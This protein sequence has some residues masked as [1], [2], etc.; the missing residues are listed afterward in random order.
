MQKQQLTSNDL[1]AALDD[2]AERFSTLPIDDL[3]VLWFLRAYITESE[4]KAAEAVSGGA[5]DKGIDA[6]FID[7]AARSVFVVQGKY[8]KILGK[9]T[10]KRTD[11]VSLAEIARRLSDQDA[12]QFSTFLAKTE[13]YVAEQ[14]RL[15]R[16]RVLN[17][18]YRIWLY[19]VTLGKVS[20]STRKD[21]ASLVKAV[22][23]DASLEVIDGKRA[24]LLFQD[25]LDGVAPPIPTLDLEMEQGPHV[26]VNAISQR[27]DDQNNI[28]SW[29]FSMQGDAVARLY[30]YGGIRLFARNIRGFLGGSTAVNQGMVATLRKEPERFIYYNNGITILCDE[31]FKKSHK[32]RDILQ[33]SNPQVINGQQTT[34]TLAQHPEQ[35]RRASVLVKVIQVSREEDNTANGFEA[36][37]SRIVAGTNWQNAIRASDLMSNDRIQIDLE[38][39]L[40]KLGYAY[41]RKRQ[42]KGEAKRAAGGKH[43]RFLK[44]EEF[45]QA[46][47][48]C[49]LEPAVAR[50]AREKLFEEALYGK[51]F[52]NSDPNYFLPRYWLMREVA[53]CARGSKQRREARWLTLHFLWS[54]LAPLVRSGKNARAFRLLCERQDRDLVGP[55]NRA[56]DRVFVAVLRFYRQNRGAGSDAVDA[57]TFFKSKRC[58]AKVFTSTYRG[59]TQFDKQFARAAEAIKE[60]DS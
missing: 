9:V 48:A 31:A 38:R 50:T 30:D 19:F 44:K 37:I 55:L 34:R 6:L 24:M 60:F 2:I 42:T 29:V 5:R 11:V 33:V 22:R 52:P 46:V 56:I 8:H 10:E 14:L 16:R 15:A 57:P 47:A 35:A 43:Y 26:K 58:S 36:L 53:Y 59:D 20:S 39:S 4:D 54:K 23:H 32:G 28:E 27:Y 17:D 18:G 41:I 45:A 40:R 3:F 7:D 21:A 1:K 12:K 13:G 25:Y 51:V 49:D